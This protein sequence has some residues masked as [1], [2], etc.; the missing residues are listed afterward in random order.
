MSIIG[1]IFTVLGSILMVF[2]LEL[3]KNTWI[4]W[5]LFVLAL[6]FLIDLSKKDRLPKGL[7][8]RFLF[9]LVSVSVCAGIVCISWPPVRRVSASDRKDPQKTDMIEEPDLALYEIFDEMYG[10]K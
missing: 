6:V 9:V 10:W 7:P 5:L 8:G 1:W 4:G 2:I 3:N